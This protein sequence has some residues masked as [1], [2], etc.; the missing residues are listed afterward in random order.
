MT[1]CIVERSQIIGEGGQYLTQGLFY[2]YRHQ[3][4]KM[5]PYTLKEYDWKGTKSMYQIYMSCGSE[6][7]AAQKILGSWKHWEILCSA[8]FFAK[9]V[10]KWR[11]EREIREAALGRATLIQQAQ[12]G[13]VSAAKA[14]VDAATKKKAGRPSKADIEAEKRKQMA[15]DSNVTSLLAH[16]N[17]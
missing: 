7:E 9:E 16:I 3:C 14:L 13:N 10:E 11:E 17:K 4:A 1:E 5:G 2:E 6:Y 12:E 8:P 15:I